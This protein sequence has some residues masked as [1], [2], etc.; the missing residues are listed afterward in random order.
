MI[1]SVERVAEHLA[2]GDVDLADRRSKRL[3]RL[4][5]IIALRSQKRFTLLELLMFLDR[6]H[7]DRTDAFEMLGETRDFGFQVRARFVRSRRLD[8][9]QR[10]D[11]GVKIEGN[12]F[13]K[14][15]ECGIRAV[16]TTL[17]FEQCVF[18]RVP[19]IARRHRTHFQLLHARFEIGDLRFDRNP[20][21]ARFAQA[22]QRLLELR[23]RVLARRLGLCLF[24]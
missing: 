24:S 21:L 15:I 3:D 12:L 13:A 9:G 18:R 17:R 4:H 16:A 5:Q 20:Q 7:V 22:D 10:I 14:Q 2:R 1:H 8:L 11:P 19:Q 23:A 6:Q